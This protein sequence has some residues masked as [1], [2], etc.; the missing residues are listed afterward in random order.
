V[1]L[2]FQLLLAL[3]QHLK[4]Q[5]PPMKLNAR[6]INITGDFGPLRFVFDQPTLDL[7]PADGG[8]GRGRDGLWDFGRFPASLTTQCHSRRGAVHDK[9][10][11]AMFASKENVRIVC[12]CRL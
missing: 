11:V 12:L 8:V 10:F 4:A 1:Q 2:D 6:L 5:L 3:V 9:R 7:L